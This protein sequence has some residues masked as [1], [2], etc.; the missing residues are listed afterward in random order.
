MYWKFNHI[1]I[2]GYLTSFSSWSFL[3]VSI[4]GDNIR[5]L[6]FHGFSQILFLA[7]QGVLQNVSVILALTVIFIVVMACVCLYTLSWQW[8]NN[9]FYSLLIIRRLEAYQVLSLWIGMKCL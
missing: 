5:F 6:S 2:F 1:K 3:G 9:K 8:A 7:P 4:I